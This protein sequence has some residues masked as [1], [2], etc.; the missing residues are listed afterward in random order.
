MAD[1][2]GRAMRLPV[3]RGLPG[4]SGR[5]VRGDVLGALTTWA[6]IVP[7]CVAYAQ[8][9]GVPPQNAFYAGLA[10]PEAPTRRE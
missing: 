6:L 2:T 4:P 3:L 10:A 1:R 5:D 8:I 9:A 7:E